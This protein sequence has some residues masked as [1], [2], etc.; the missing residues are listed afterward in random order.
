MPRQD[1]LSNQQIADLLTYIRNN[2]EN[3]AS[4]IKSD[5]VAKLRK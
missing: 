4:A 1:Y 3:K 5:E 2:F